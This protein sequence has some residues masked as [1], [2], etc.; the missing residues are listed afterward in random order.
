MSIAWFRFNM[1]ISMSILMS[2]FMMVDGDM[3][4]LMMDWDMMNWFVMVDW[5]VVVDCFVVSVTMVNRNVMNG[6][7]VV[8][9]LVV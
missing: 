2:R 6:L 3:M 9:W 7:V 4:S 5:L 8:D 1:S